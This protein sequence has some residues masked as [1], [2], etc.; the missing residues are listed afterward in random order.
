MATGAEVRYSLQSERPRGPKWFTLCNSGSREDQK[1]E[2]EARILPGG[3]T[4][5][6]FLVR[7]LFEKDGFRQIQVAAISEGPR[8]VPFAK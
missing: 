4:R 7:I 1:D 6:Q 5:L 3:R 8:V 2:S